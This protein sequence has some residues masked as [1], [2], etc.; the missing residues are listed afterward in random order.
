V[1]PTGDEPAPADYDDAVR[2]ELDAFRE[3]F[4][5]PGTNLR[6]RYRVVRDGEPGCFDLILAVPGAEAPYGTDARLC[7]D[8]A[9]GAPRLSERRFDNGV[10]ETDRADT[11]LTTVSDADLALPR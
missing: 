6:P 1:V 7:F 4:T 5:P 3:W 11:I 9:T 2:Q 8:E 10:I